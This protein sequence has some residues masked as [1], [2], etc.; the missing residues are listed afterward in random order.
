ML[1]LVADERFDARAGEV[2]TAVEEGEF[3]EKGGDDRGGPE[4]GKE[5][6]GGGCSASGGEDVVNECDLLSVLDGVFVDFNDGF[7]VFEGVGGRFCFPRELA[8]FSDGDEAEA[9]LMCDRCG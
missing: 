8:L 4:A 6:Y 1:A 7:T 2:F 5:F 9:E 3:H